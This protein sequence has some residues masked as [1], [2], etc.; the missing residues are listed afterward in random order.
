SVAMAKGTIAAP[1]SDE[2]LWDKFENCTGRFLDHEQQEALRQ[3]L[4][5]MKSNQDARTLTALL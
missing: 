3:I 2:Q 1:L 5:N 4:S